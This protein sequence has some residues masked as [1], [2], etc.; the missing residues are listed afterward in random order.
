MKDEPVQ[1]L[2]MLCCLETSLFLWV[3]HTVCILV[4]VC[5]CI[6]YVSFVLPCS[7][8]TCVGLSAYQPGLQGFSSQLR[9]VSGKQDKE[10]INVCSTGLFDLCCLAIARCVFLKFQIWS[11]WGLSGKREL[12]DCPV[13]EV[14]KW[15]WF[16]ELT[17]EGGGSKCICL[18]NWSHQNYCVVCVFVRQLM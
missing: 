17:W 16:I 7:G 10:C 4:Y 11:H 15:V 6:M 1:V 2:I 18:S 8:Y 13:W 12:W 5:I 3:L 9:H 14:G